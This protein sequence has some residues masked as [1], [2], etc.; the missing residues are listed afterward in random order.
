MSRARLL[1]FAGVLLFLIG[2]FSGLAAQQ[3][4]NPRLAL[5]GHLEGVLNGMFLMIVGLFWNR[6]K[7]SAALQRATAA[8]IL[9]GTWANWA[10]TLLGA[11]FGTKRF[12]PIAGAGYEAAEWQELVVNG[13][14]I[15]M[16]LAMVTGVSLLLYGLRG[17]DDPA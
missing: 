1:I 13:G 15:I 11:A 7:L 9:F 6:L 17:N 10:L 2:I 16:I 3:F 4:H 12:T 5:S 8:L 14:L